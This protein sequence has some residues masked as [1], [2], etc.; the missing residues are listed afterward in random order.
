MKV[1]SFLVV[2]IRS[3]KPIVSVKKPG[4]IRNIAAIAIDAPDNNS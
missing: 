1:I 3:R 4:I 2:G